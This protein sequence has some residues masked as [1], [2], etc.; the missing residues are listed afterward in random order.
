MRRT[1]LLICACLVFGLMRLDAGGHL[2]MIGGGNRPD[3]V[4]DR[5]IALAGG[6]EASIVIIPAASEDPLDSSLY[7]RHQ[8]ETR[9]ARNVK[10]LILEKGRVDLAENLEAVRQAGGIFFTGGD[11]NRLTDYLNGTALLE[12]VRDVHRRGGVISGTSAGAAVMSAVMITGDENPAVP[13]GQES[14]TSIQSGRIVTAP[15]F[16]FLTQ[17]V[18]DQHFVRR[19]RHNRLMSL[20]LENPSLIGIGIDE[21]TAAVVGPDGRMEVVG[22][23]LVV[24]YDARKARAI[25]TDEHGHLSALDISVHLLK[26][27]MV[28][29]LDKMEI[30]K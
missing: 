24:V 7:A 1:G 16:G 2:V 25:A 14:F 12:A 27:G 9:G 29:D 3:I 21:E 19:K 6:E 11:Q 22:N 5:I 18:V 30:V 26:N 4:M 10:F 8:F 17:A 20:I 23:S 28:L 13:E 15:G